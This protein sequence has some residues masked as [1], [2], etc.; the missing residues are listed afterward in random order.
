VKRIAS[1][2]PSPAM[3]VALLSLFVA[4]GGV[5]YAATIGTGQIKNNSIRTQDLRNND[6]RSKDI[7]N[8]A[9]HG[10]DVKGNTLTGSDINESKLGQVPSARVADLAALTAG[11]TV[12]PRKSAT[13]AA[14]QATAPEVALGT[15][16]PFRFYAKC[17]RSG[18]NLRAVEYVA[19][20]SGVATFSTQDEGDLPS[21]ANDEYLTPTTAEDLREVE[22]ASA[23][24][25]SVDAENGDA[26]F[27]AA[28]DALAITGVVGLAQAK[29]GAPAAGNG[30]FGTGDGCIF[31]GVVFG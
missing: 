10:R 17:F 23:A 29:Q 5:G 21:N 11:V 31:G 1:I 7:R 13:P 8:N 20:T 30:P 24:A 26:D 4:M 18:A 16:G 2:R 14:S 28:T 15:R 27:R 9:V 25:D 12:F 3:A 22:S 19:L 6:I